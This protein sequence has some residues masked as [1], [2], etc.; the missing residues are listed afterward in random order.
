DSSLTHSTL[1]LRAT[2]S[3]IRHPCLIMGQC[4]SNFEGRNT[5]GAVSVEQTEDSLSISQAPLW[6]L[7]KV[8]TQEYPDLHCARVDLDPKADKEIGTDALYREIR[9]DTEEDQVAFRNENRY[10]ARLVRYRQTQAGLELPNGPYRLQISERG[11]L[12]NL[13]LARSPRRLPQA[14]E[15]EIRVRASGL[16]FRDVLSAL[17]MYP[18]DPGP[19]G[20]EC[21]G[22][23]AAVG[24]GAKDF[25][26]GDPV[27]AMAPGSFSQYVTVPADLVSR[28]PEQLGF[29]EAATIPVVFLTAHYALH[30]LAKLSAGDRVL[31]HAAAGGVGL[32]TIQLAQ[33][34]GAEVFATASPPK[35]AFLESIGIEHIM[36][37]RTTDFARQI[38]EIT[39]GQ[40]VDAVLNSLTSEGFI[41]RS[42]SAL[43]T[44]GRFLEISKAGVWQP[45]QVRQVR[46][47]VDYL[48]ASPAE[49]L[50]NM[51]INKYFV[52]KSLRKTTKSTLKSY[53]YKG[54]RFSRNHM[55]YML[56][57][58]LPDSLFVNFF[59]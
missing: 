8:I 48:P 54:V 12:D 25:E 43:G 13:E 58:H 1:Q 42:L 28:K 19:L 45:E 51:L 35:W 31:I 22:E 4:P 49:K 38:M 7:G 9:S 29:E 23:I 32:A 21:A 18:G 5:Q 44:G 11:T 57:S 16:N 36:N 14:G 10:V 30:H 56:F 55:I 50:D 6:G 39:G 17:G 52:Q 41:E 59:R 40:G 37:S 27:M 47:D 46:P 20:G 2:M 15:V 34:A 26:I 24:E 33:L 3:A 53:G